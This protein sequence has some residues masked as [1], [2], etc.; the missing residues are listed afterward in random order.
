MEF[1]FSNDGG[2]RLVSP[3]LTLDELLSFLSKDITIGS[4]DSVCRW[5]H[6]PAN[7]L[8]WVEELIKS[9][10]K[11][12]SSEERLY[13]ATILATHPFVNATRDV[14]E[15]PPHSRSLRPL[16]TAKAN[17]KDRSAL[18]S[19][20]VPYIQVSNSRITALV[21]YTIFALLL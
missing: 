5:F 14:L 12:R 18:F 6:V 10:Y 13:A 20:H 11:H 21:I 8:G 19:L 9:I 2:H 3:T 4:T 7:H 17:A 16:A 1:D 15:G